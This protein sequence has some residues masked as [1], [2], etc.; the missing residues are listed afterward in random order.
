[1]HLSKKALQNVLNAIELLIGDRGKRV[2]ESNLFKIKYISQVKY[3]GKIPLKMKHR[4]V[5]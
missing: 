1:L 3:R 2:K 5:K 4:N